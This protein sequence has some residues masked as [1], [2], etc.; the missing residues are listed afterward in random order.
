MNQ[1]KPQT[2][3]HLFGVFRNHSVTFPASNPAA[4]IPIARIPQV[5]AHDRFA[6][7]DHFP[8]YREKIPVAILLW[9]GGLFHPVT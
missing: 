3:V 5:P 7:P 8:D 4:A 9:V 6:L 2:I 1:D